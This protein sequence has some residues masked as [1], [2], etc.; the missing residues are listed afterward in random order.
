MGW[1]SS[2]PKQAF[3]V[4]LIAALIVGF[5]AGAASGGSQAEADKAASDAATVRHQLADAR[6]ELARVRA[7]A[8]VLNTDLTSAKRRASTAE[9]A[10]KTLSAKAEVPRFTG[11]DA[12]DADDNELVGQLDWKLRTVS[13][14]SASAQPGTVISQSPSEGHVL[15]AGR[16]ITL[17]VARKPPPKPKQ[18]VTIKTLTGASST[19]TDEFRVPSG[20]KARLRYS[21]PQDSNNSI[22]LYRAP[23]E[24]MDLLL[25]EIGPQQGTTRLYERG[26]FY[27][28]VTGSYTIQVEIFKRP[29]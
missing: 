19:K 26:T 5:A 13:R 7:Q 23:M 6:S 17:V 22:I 24:Y 25:N 10:V 4:T 12:S 28:D 8:T 18:W 14:V 29:S 2:K 3:W 21:M 1:V 15:K 27:L 9:T 11:R 16:S 20:V